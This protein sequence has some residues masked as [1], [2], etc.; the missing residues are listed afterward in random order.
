MLE[1]QLRRRG[2]SPERLMAG[3]ENI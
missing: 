3:N 2:I 1:D